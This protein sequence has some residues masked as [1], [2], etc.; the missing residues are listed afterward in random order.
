MNPVKCVRNEAPRNSS[1]RAQKLTAAT[2]LVPLGVSPPWR[3]SGVFLVLFW[4]AA[5]RLASTSACVY[6]RSRHYD[7]L[8]D[9]GVTDR[10]QT[11]NTFNCS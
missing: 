5:H 3:V 1:N 10:A 7:I 6:H 9:T 4:R 8:R 2:A 11:V